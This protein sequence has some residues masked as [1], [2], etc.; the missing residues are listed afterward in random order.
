MMRPDKETAE[1]LA[2]LRFKY[3]KLLPLANLMIASQAIQYNMIVVTKDKDFEN[4]EEL[5]KIIIN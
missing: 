1:I 3:E 2:K 4:I 5:N